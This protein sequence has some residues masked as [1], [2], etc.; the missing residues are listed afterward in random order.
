LVFAAKPEL[1]AWR[2]AP[3][4]VPSGLLH[5]APATTHTGRRAPRF[6]FVKAILKKLPE[7]AE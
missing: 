1:P 6:P 2:Q 7:D 4:A 5:P 3:P